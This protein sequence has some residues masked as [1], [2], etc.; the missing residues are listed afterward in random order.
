[1]PRKILSPDEKKRLFNCYLPPATI[2]RM[3]TICVRR[4]ILACKKFSEGVFVQDLVET[5]RMPKKP[6]PEQVAAY[7]AQYGKVDPSLYL[8]D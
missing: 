8:T 4:S 3:K 1:M 5:T 6:T 2:I 7:E